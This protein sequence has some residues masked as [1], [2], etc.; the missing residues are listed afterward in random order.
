LMTWFSKSYRGSYIESDHKEKANERRLVSY[1]RHYTAY[2]IEPSYSQLFRFN[3]ISHEVTI[4][5]R[6][7]NETA[8][9]KAYRS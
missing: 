3:D 4:G 2:A 5:Y 6:Y 1:P 7:L 9:E 8:D